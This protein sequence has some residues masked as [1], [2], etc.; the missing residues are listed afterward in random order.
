[1]RLALGRSRIPR[2][3]SWKKRSKD[4][5]KEDRSSEELADTN[6]RQGYLVFPRI[7]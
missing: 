2:M 3:P 7:C 5:P 1:M 4:E 6:I